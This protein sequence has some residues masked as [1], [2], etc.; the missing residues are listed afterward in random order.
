MPDFTLVGLSVMNIDG[1]PA[2][3]R[4]TS[5]SYRRNISEKEREERKR[6]RMK[7]R[8]GKTKTDKDRQNCILLPPLAR[9]EQFSSLSSFHNN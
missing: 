3:P 8:K 2:S 6:N 9:L 4:T 5:F 1:A 7:Q